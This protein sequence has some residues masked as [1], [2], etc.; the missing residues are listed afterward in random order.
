MGLD[1]LINGTRNDTITSNI[2]QLTV[3]DVDEDNSDTAEIIIL[4][5]DKNI[6]IPRI[7]VK[8]NIYYDHVA[9]GGQFV[10]NKISVFLTDF[11]EKKCLTRLIFISVAIPNGSPAT[12]SGCPALADRDSLVDIDSS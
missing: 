12:V 11:A 9:V 7:G 6:P 2:N 4:V 5:G 8:V 3:T 10:V 1:I